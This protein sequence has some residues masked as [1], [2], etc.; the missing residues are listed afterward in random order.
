M[1]T[2]Y[3]WIDDAVREYQRSRA[4]LDNQVAAGLLTK[5]KIP[6]DHRTY[7]KRDEL[8]TL[9]RPQEF[10]KGQGGNGGSQAG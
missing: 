2:N 4:W 5:V 7:L 9:L 8:D 6:G 1:D 10:R 3:I